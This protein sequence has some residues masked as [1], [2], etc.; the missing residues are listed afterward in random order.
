MQEVA[1][2]LKEFDV[3]IVGAGQAGPALSRSL[4][5]AGQRVALAERK[6]IGG[7]CVNF[8]CTPTKAALASA[9][10]A[11]LA[12]RASEF[13][14]GVPE[15]RP[16]FPAVLARAA[17]IAQQMR[18][19]LQKSFSGHDNP[20]LMH[21]HARFVGR[22]DERFRLAV[23]GEEVIARHVVL[24]PGTRS[25]LPHIDGLHDIDLIMA[26]NWLEHRELPRHLAVV[27]G[28]YIGLE[29][30][31]FYRRMGAAV[32]VVESNSHVAAEED[33]DVS[34]ALQRMLAGEGIVFRT[35]ASAKRFQKT[36]DGVT[37][38]LESDGKTEELAASHVFI[39]LGRKP[40]TDDLG[41]ENIGL[42]PTDK[43][44]LEVD[45]RLGTAIPGVWAVGDIRGGPMFTHTAWDDYRIIESQ[46]IGDKSRT[47]ARIVPYA[48]FTDPPLGRV[49]MTETQAGQAGKNF[50][51]ARYDMLGNGKA[52]EVGETEGFIKIVVDAENQ[53]LLGAAVLATE[54][55]EL[56]HI[57][58]A[59]MNASAPCHVLENAIH[60]HP[61]LA[62]AIQR[63]ISSL[64]G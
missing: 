4:A 6:Q 25:A 15:V 63:A 26:E 42:H 44:T 39:A 29:M 47:T 34:V 11:H 21:G 51:V 3:F 22:M 50:K 5:R 27:G 64:R 46:L 58:V 10:V 59:M 41:L 30:A 19:S 2:A 57:Y 38:S 60:I 36:Q 12:R 18:D 53:C 20:V 31:Q 48:V 14:I 43:G 62:E 23:D 61:T 17:G 7:S 49:G 8:G 9:R 24:D 13:G 40:N 55:A 1:M 16:D 32:T 45:E 54:G 33:Q 56:V 37:L 28:G 35:N 52:M